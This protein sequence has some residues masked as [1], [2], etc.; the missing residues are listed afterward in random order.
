MAEKEKDK[1][2]PNELVPPVG[3]AHL[4]AGPAQ[5]GFMEYFKLFLRLIFKP[6]S[7]NLYAKVYGVNLSGDDQ[8]KPYP[9]LND[10]ESAENIR[11]RIGAGATPEKVS[12]SKLHEAIQENAPQV[13]ID[14]EKENVPLTSALNEIKQENKRQ[15]DATT[16]AENHGN[17]IEQAAAKGQQDF[18]SA[19]KPPEDLTAEHDPAPGH[20][21]NPSI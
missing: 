5:I 16:S 14:A 9:W 21:P 10:K 8:R 13:L 12:P 15:R 3:S 2:D 6:D 7:F 4:T 11:K 1:H 18:Q 19:S 17:K 20:N